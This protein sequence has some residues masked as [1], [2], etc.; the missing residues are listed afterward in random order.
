MNG[1]ERRYEKSTI[2]AL[3]DYPFSILRSA[4][5]S[6]FHHSTRQCKSSDQSH[7]A[8][9]MKHL[10]ITKVTAAMYHG[11][12]SL[13]DMTIIIIDTGCLDYAVALAAGSAELGG[14]RTPS[15][16]ISIRN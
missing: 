9:Q 11:T 6:Y 1:S 14:E 5:S 3:F 15:W 7:P 4:I 8:V 13:N 10:K 2:S 12:V 16:C